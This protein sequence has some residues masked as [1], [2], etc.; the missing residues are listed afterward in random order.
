MA[1]ILQKNEL[2]TVPA[3]GWLYIVYDNKDYRASVEALLRLVDKAHVGLGNVDNTSDQ[4]KPVSTA[5]AQAL[6]A[7]QQTVDQLD[8]DIDTLNQSL[9][10]YVSLS[11]FNTAIDAL[12]LAIN[13]RIT[14]AEMNQAIGDALMPITQSLQN[15]IATVNQNTQQIQALSSAMSDTVSAT[16]MNQAIATSSQGDRDYASQQVSAL[17]Q[18]VSQSLLQINQTLFNK[19]D[20]NHTHQASAIEGLPE[21]IQSEIASADV[22]VLTEDNR[23]W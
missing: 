20:L 13:S 10:N 2:A 6:A 19:A 18:A 3:T 17:S 11:T 12:T 9:A 5:V 1:N 8:G 23:E 15:V 14:E 16:Q 4:D 22:L 7:I 21:L